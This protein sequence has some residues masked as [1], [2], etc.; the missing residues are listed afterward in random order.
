MFKNML[1]SYDLIVINCETQHFSLSA[2]LTGA[3]VG[4]HRSNNQIISPPEAV[5]ARIP[6]FDAMEGQD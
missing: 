4:Y 6:Q 5:Q 1:I 3:V 2:S